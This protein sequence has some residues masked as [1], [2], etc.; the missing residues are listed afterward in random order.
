M[1]PRKRLL[2]SGELLCFSRGGRNEDHITP[3][4]CPF[5][6]QQDMVVDV[7][8]KATGKTT[9]FDGFLKAYREETDEAAVGDAGAAAEG[10][11]ALASPYV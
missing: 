6:V 7:V 10:S 4:G 8:F 2:F 5:R 1:L 3:L 9:V 11:R